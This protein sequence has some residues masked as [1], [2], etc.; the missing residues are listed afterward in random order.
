[1]HTIT[2]TIAF[3]QA[4]VRITSA[5]DS[6]PGG[7]SPNGG[8]GTVTV[9]ARNTGTTTW[10]ANGY[11]MRLVRTGRISVANNVMPVITD[12]APNGQATFTFAIS[13]NGFGTGGISLQMAGATGLFQN[14]A[15]K[16]IVCQ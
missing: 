8:T 14:S 15:G 6:M 7:N 5:P 11:A 16:T 4:D 13:C 12:V 2:N 3:D 9:T 1:V 10:V